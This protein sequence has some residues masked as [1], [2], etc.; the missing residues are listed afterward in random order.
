MSLLTSICASV[1]IFVPK[2]GVTLFVT[3]LFLYSLTV[4]Y[5][6]A[7]AEGIS[8]MITKYNQRIEVLEGKNGSE[9]N[10]MK[11]L[12]MFNSVRGIFQ[13]IMSF[14]GGFVV[15][16]TKSSH[17]FISGIILS[18]YPVI[19]CLQTL[20]LFKEEKVRK[21]EGIDYGRSTHKCIS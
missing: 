16:R 9:D 13:A 18:S 12:G 4:S 17:L 20:F 19:F 2:P 7:L 1:L 10:S 3:S 21:C 6:D 5:I 8:A 15:E 11:A 14:V